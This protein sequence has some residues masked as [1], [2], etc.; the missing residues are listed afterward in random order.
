M[1]NRFRI[2]EMVLGALW[3]SLFWAIIL[4]WQAAYAPTEL[5]KQHCYETLQKTGQ[6]AEEC[7]TFWERT[8][9]DPVAAFT[10]VLALSTIALWITTVY[11]LMISRRDFVFTHRPRV[12]VRFIQG[13]LYT[14][15][16]QQAIIVTLVNT[17]V[18]RAII[19]EFGAD[20]ARREKET[21]DWPPPGVS[22]TARPI[23]PV[24]LASGERHSFRIAV[25]Y[26][27]LHILA[28]ALDIYDWC[29]VGEIKY[30]DDNGVTRET[31]FCRIYNDTTKRFI[32]SPNADEE[33]Q[34]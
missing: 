5:E 24:T 2:P 4:A 16:G 26:T 27:D 6:K 18:S 3:S 30:N 17:G 23:R 21:G 15:D 14:D 31:G 28:D 12:I 8:T 34:D 9:S 32:S 29:A 22:A 7:K 11:Q 10:F 13:P 20:L 19:T 25:P 33:Y 1:A